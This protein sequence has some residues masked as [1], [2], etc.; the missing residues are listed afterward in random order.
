MGRLW[1]VSTDILK[2]QSPARLDRSN[3]I[4]ITCGR[5]TEFILGSGLLVSRLGR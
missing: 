4:G 1:Q 3:C 5:K 2:E